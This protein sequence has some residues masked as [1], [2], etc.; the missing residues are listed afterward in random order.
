MLTTLFIA[1]SALLIVAV[2]STVFGCIL[3][4]LISPRVVSRITPEAAAF[5]AFVG[6]GAFSL[7]VGLF[8]YAGAP[9][10][11]ATAI[12][13]LVVV[14]LAALALGLRPQAPRFAWKRIDLTAIV[15]LGAGTAFGCFLPILL[16]DAVNICND[17]YTYLSIGESLQKHPFDS[18]I[19]HDFDH[20]VLGSALL[21]QSAGL[22]MGASFLLA[23]IQSLL[24]GTSSL[25]VYPGVAAW[26]LALNVVGLFLI[27]R[28]VFGMKRWHAYV[29]CAIAVATLNPV[30]YSMQAGF[31]PQLFGTASLA[32]I[33]AWLARLLIPRHQSLG[34]ATLAGLLAAMQLSFYSELT[35]LIALMLGCFVVLGA[36]RAYATSQFMTFARLATIGLLAAVVFGNFEWLRFVRVFKMQ[37]YAVVG[38]N[39]DWSPTQFWSFA[40]G[41]RSYFMTRYA[42]LFLVETIVATIAF[43]VGMLYAYRSRSGRLLFAVT[44]VLFLLTG[45]FL[46]KR[47]PWTNEF[48]HTWSIFKLT[49]WAFPILFAAQAAGVAAMLRSRPKLSGAIAVVL[50]CITVQGLAVHWKNAKDTVQRV[51]VDMAVTSPMTEYRALRSKL[52]DL[53]NPPIYFVHPEEGL[54]PRVTASYLL[55]P[56]RFVSSWKHCGYLPQ[57]FQRGELPGPHP[58]NTLY[59]APKQ[60]CLSSNSETFPGGFVHLDMNSVAIVGMVS[61]NGVERWGGGMSTWVGKD[62]VRLEFWSP[63]P[64]RVTVR[65]YF[66]PGPSR[67][68]AKQGKLQLVHPDGRRQ[69]VAL[70]FEAGPHCGEFDVDLPAGRSDLRVAATDEPTVTQFPSGDKR[71]MLVGMSRIELLD[72]AVQTAGRSE[73]TVK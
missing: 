22:R 66:N 62:S 54:W 57:E 25:D 51:R 11:G 56:S 31:F 69:D 60:T 67:P 23:A 33:L 6:T 15:V 34:N 5:A 45:Y 3:L 47:N 17:S 39:V 10:P 53:G 64:Q 8:C 41:V 21:Y 48:G 59:L 58:K 19:P 20:P 71:V 70:R 43:G 37:L 9:A 13:L 4:K 68:E 2:L 49:K 65:S 52:N 7:L 50:V 14:A 35:P 27:C 28:W 61:P 26:G 24:P 30:Y 12:T 36:Y 32:V 55:Y 18:S 46:F 73:R 44:G 38:W 72:S 63:Q 16:G 42:T 29:A 1:T 40:L